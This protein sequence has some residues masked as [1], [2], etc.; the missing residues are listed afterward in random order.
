MYVDEQILGAVVDH[1]LPL[2]ENTFPL[3]RDA[4]FVLASKVSGLYC[5]YICKYIYI[6]NV[7]NRD[8][9]GINNLLHFCLL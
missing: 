5:I 4:L 1:I 2:D 7:A 6:I 8:K 9:T 3:I